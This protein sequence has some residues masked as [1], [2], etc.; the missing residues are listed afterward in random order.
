MLKV[1]RE[2]F[3]PAAPPTVAPPP[4]L[5][6][7]VDPVPDPTVDLV[8]YARDWV[9]SGRLALTADRLS[10]VLNGAASFDV[11][12]ALVEDFHGGPQMELHNVAVARKDILLVHAGGPRGNPARR[13]HTRQHPIVARVGPYDIRGYVHSQP[14]VGALASLHRRK[15][16]IAVTDAI[17]EFELRSKQQVRRAGVVIF[18]R[19]A[20]DWI[21]EGKL[22]PFA[23][24]SLPVT[25]GLLVK[26]FTASFESSPFGSL[27]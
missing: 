11:L 13:Q 17:I 20:V 9:L 24:P 10:D 2:R 21:T 4:A 22:D 1:L 25:R 23:L 27:T 16:M 8:V 18:N 12:D 14:G 7:D 26:D 15:P 5:D 3:Q 19:D 6:T